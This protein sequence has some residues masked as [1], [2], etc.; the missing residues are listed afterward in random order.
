FW[1]DRT[2]QSGYGWG[3]IR[4]DT[5]HPGMVT[6]A[7]RAGAPNIPDPNLGYEIGTGMDWKLLEGFTL[8]LTT[9]YW[10][11]GKWFSYA[12][13]DKAIPKWSL[14]AAKGWGI[15]PNRGIDPVW[16]MELKLIGDF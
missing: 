16:G 14:A 7:D 10:K 9:S 13:V 6:W 1:A 15:L 12:C 5:T 4:P 11:P 2:S 8:T 3:F